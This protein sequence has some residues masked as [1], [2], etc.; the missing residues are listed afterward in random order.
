MVPH[1]FIRKVCD[2]LKGHVKK[3]A[4]GMSLIKVWAGGALPG[5]LAGTLGQGG[6]AGSSLA[7]RGCKGNPRIL[8]Q[9]LN[10]GVGGCVWGEWEVGAES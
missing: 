5:Q 8:E 9:K 10:S 3:D 7:R 1:Q 4:V 6:R 2:Q